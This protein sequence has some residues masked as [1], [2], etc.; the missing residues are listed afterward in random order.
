MAVPTVVNSWIALAIAS[1]INS[2]PLYA[3]SGILT[4]PPV[5]SVPMLPALGW[6]ALIVALAVLGA[7]MLRR[8]AR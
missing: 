7:V 5:V 4:V 3:V 6:I 1:N 8:R 2:F